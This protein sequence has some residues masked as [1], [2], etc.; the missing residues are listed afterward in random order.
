MVDEVRNVR[1]E[2]VMIVLIYRS[3]VATAFHAQSKNMFRVV[4]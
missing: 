3:P 2:R 4:T 1:L